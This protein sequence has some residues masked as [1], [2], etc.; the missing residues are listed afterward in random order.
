MSTWTGLNDRANPGTYVWEDGSTCDFSGNGGLNTVSGPAET[1]AEICINPGF[2]TSAI[3][4]GNEDLMRWGVNEPNNN[5]GGF[6]EACG[7]V[8]VDIDASVGRGNAWWNDLPCNDPVN[9]NRAYACNNPG[10]LCC[11]YFL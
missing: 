9:W 10:I 7:E 2:D 4:V 5:G 3:P 1:L 11:T 8:Y 6:A